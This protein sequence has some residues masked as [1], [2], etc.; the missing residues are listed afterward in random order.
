MAEMISPAQFSIPRLI[1][2]PS[3]ITL[4]V[5]L[6]RLVGELLHWSKTWFNPEQG[7][8]LAVVGIVWLVPVFGIYF[9]LK[10]SG[11]G[12]GT[13]HLGHAIAH[14]ILGAILL[15]VG[16]YLLNGGVIPGMRGVV[17]MWA[18]AAWGGILQWRT[19]RSLFKVLLA[20]GYAARIPVAVV[21]ALATWAGW[22]SHYS[23]AVP[24]ESKLEMYFI[25][26]FIPQ[27][28]WWV[29]FTIVTGSLFGTL[30]T[31]VRTRSTA[32]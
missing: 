3:V 7:G 10:L 17:V 28:V 15:G 16:F 30:A 31:A 13:E 22:Q 21:M 8:F 11:M 20:Y 19:W 9:A 12:Q 25:A 14:A 29:A 26:A 18:L 24:G 4:A 5:T 32:N 6:L 23:A 2:A 27:L 1:F